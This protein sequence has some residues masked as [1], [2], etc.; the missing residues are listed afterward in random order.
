MMHTSFNEYEDRLEQFQQR[1]EELAVEKEM[2][3]S[4]LFSAKKRLERVKQEVKSNNKT[5]TN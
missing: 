4:R 3:L 1:L 2:L 5:D